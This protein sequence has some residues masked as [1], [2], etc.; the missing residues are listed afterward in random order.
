[1]CIHIFTKYIIYQ[2]RIVAVSKSTSVYNIS[3]NRP[4]PSYYIRNPH[5]YTTSLTTDQDQVTISEIQHQYTTSLT[6]DQTK[7][8]YQKSTSVY[9]ISDNR[10]GPS[11]YI[12]NPHQ[13]TT[14]LTTDQDQVTI[15]EIHISIQHL[16]QQTRTKLLYQK[17]TSV[18][19]I[20]DNRP[21]PS[22]YIRNPDQ[23]TT[24]LTTDQDQVTISEIHISKQHLWQQTRTKLLYQKSTSVYNISDNRPGPSLLY[25]KSHQYTTSL[26]TDQ[27][28]VTISEIH[29]SIQRLWQQT[30]TKLLYQK[31]TSVYNISDNR[32]GPSYYIK[33]HISIQHLWQQTRTKLLYQKSTS[34]YNISDNRP[35]PSYYIKNPHQYTTSLTTDQ[36]QVTI[37][38]IHISIHISDNRPGPSYYIRNP[39]QYTTSLTTDQDQVTISEIHIQYTTS[40]T[41]DQDQVT[42]SE[43]H[44]SIQ[45]LWQQTRT[46]LLYQK[47]TSVYNISDNR[48][49]PSYYI[50]NPHQYTTSLTTDQDQVTISEIINDI[51]LMLFY[52]SFIHI[53]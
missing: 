34:V 25:Q 47:S 40:L 5:Q 21:G 4:R 32:P 10:P 43:I 44:I 30:R 41:T 16:W 2:K 29:I 12:R 1:M 42:I 50:R 31:S 18:Y 7:L 8:L 38:K 48:P 11:Y 39:H 15:S 24:S 22:Y 9:N 3:D 26:T 27:D 45:H 17:S 6:T 20:S 36:D 37:S 52:A 23:Y 28:Q 33:I 46:K 35:G 14:S 49:G 53:V 19:N 13:Y 51:K